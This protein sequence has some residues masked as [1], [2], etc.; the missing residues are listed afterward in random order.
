MIRK[1]YILNNKILKYIN[2]KWAELK[3]EINNHQ[4]HW[5]I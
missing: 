1:E 3:G 2:K 4:P 5:E